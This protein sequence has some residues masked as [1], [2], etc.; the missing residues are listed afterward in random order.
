MLISRM[1]EKEFPQPVMAAAEVLSL[2]LFAEMAEEQI[3]TVPAIADS[4]S[5]WHNNCGV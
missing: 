3:Q 1:H 2:P 5:V 4:R